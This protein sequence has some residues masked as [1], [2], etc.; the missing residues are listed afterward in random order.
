MEERLLQLIQQNEKLIE[1]LGEANIKLDAVEAGLGRHLNSI[2]G[3][4]DGLQM[5]LPSGKYPLDLISAQEGR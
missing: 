5:R 1:M 3:E 2:N 4:L